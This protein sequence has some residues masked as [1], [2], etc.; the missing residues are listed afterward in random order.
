MQVKHPQLY[1]HLLRFD[2]SARGLSDGELL[3]SLQAAVKNLGR[4]HQHHSQ[5]KLLVEL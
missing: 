1:E 4:V 3:T 2:P 5:V